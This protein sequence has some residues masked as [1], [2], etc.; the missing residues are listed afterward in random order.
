LTDLSGYRIYYG[1]ES[2][3]YSDQV[4][5]NDATASSH[6]LS[7]SSGDYFVAMT[8]LDRD[9]NESAYSNEVVKTSP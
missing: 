9:G 3:N 1:S 7:L 5:I 8:A 2:R 6:T 4:E